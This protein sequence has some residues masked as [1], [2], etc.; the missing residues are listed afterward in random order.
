MSYLGMN[1]YVAL[2][3]V[4]LLASAAWIVGV[5]DEG[6]YAHLELAR[7]DL[8]CVD[9]GEPGAVVTAFALLLAYGYRLHA[10]EAVPLGIEVDVIKGD[11]A[12]GVFPP[13][14]HLL[15][16]SFYLHVSI[17]VTRV[18]G[19]VAVFPKSNTTGQR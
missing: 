6:V 17:L 16:C 8:R 9:K 4:Y 14:D 13:D 11:G 5:R 18:F 2:A 7:T 15:N 3:A 19:D 12:A 10:R 1:D